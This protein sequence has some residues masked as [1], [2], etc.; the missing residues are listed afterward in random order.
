MKTFFTDFVTFMGRIALSLIFL[1]SGL[2]KIG[3]Y[4]GN[5]AFM[6]AKGI[7]FAPF[8]LYAA[9]FIELLGS[10]SLITGYRARLG[11]LL[12]AIYLIPTTYIFHY[13][14]AFNAGLLVTEQKIQMISL[15]K[16]ISIF[17]G[18]LMVFGNGSG[19]WSFGK[20]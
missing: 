13:L 17:G 9:V 20:D 10:F 15:M 16:N 19:K 3:D 14:P 18:L 7:P 5:V 8:F 2:S 1:L 12:L 6:Q 11:A 4:S